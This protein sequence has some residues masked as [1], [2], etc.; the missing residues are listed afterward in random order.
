MET[1]FVEISLLVLVF[2]ILAPLQNALAPADH[3]APANSIF[4]RKPR[5]RVVAFLFRLTAAALCCLIGLSLFD[6]SQEACCFSLFIAQLVVETPRICNYRLFKA[7]EGRTRLLRFIQALLS[8][9]ITPFASLAFTRIPSWSSIDRFFVDYDDVF[10]DDEENRRMI[11][12]N[13]ETQVLTARE[14]L[15]VSVVSRY[16]T[17]YELSRTKSVPVYASLL[18]ACNLE[19]CLTDEQRQMLAN[20]DERTADKTPKAR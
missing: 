13:V 14:Q 20:I 9:A 2:L 6:I 8:L 16:L 4:S 15:C 3:Y 10:Y 17:G 19:A 18:L 11:G 5:N 7:L 12:G 1:P